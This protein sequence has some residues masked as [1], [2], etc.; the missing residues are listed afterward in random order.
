[1]NR[2]LRLL[3]A[4][5]AL[6]A[7]SAY[8]AEGVWASV[9]MP[10]MDEAAAHAMDAHAGMNHGAPSPSDDTPVPD[11]PLGMTSMGSSCVAVSLPSSVEVPAP[12]LES[13]TAAVTSGDDI[14]D[15]L[16]TTSHFRP[17]RA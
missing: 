10:G 5:V 1:M 11:C 8:F 3:G 9:C 7:F 17:P 13:A 2:R 16:L 15:S 4:L 6:L 12:A 14:H